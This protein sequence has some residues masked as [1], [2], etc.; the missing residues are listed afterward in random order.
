M[1]VKQTLWLR[2][3]DVIVIDGNTEAEAL[4]WLMIVCATVESLA[5]SGG[6]EDRAS[7]HHD[8]GQVSLISPEAGMTLTTEWAHWQGERD[9]NMPEW[10]GE[11][12]IHR[13]VVII[14]ERRLSDKLRDMIYFQ[15]ITLF[16]IFVRLEVD[17]LRVYSKSV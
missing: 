13:K 15:H 17:S 3:K 14:T 12:Q 8:H 16:C 5:S 6:Q 4:V 10:A 11:D 1:I 2:A 7:T 9:C